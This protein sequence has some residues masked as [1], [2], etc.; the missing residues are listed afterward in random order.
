VG[1]GASIHVDVDT[2]IEFVTYGEKGDFMGYI[3]NLS[4]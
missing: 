3:F 1:I 4:M 2:H